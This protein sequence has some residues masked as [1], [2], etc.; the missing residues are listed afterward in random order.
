MSERLSTTVCRLGIAGLG[1]ALVCNDARLV[2]TLQQRYAGFLGP[3]EIHIEV[4][5]D[6]LHAA[7]E[8]KRPEITP[9][10]TP[11]QVIFNAPGFQG[12]I[13]LQAG[14]AALIAGLLR[15]VC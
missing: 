12:E 9:I 13:D 14:R 3:P 11:G 2:E 5:I 7:P 15:S 10:F 6:H 4:S 1:A 8:R